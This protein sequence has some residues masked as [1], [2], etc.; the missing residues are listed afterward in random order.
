[1]TD[2]DAVDALALESDFA[3]VVRVDRAG[4]PEFAQAYGFAHR[5]HEIPNTVDTQFGTASGAK[6]FT[7]LA[8][9]HLIEQGTLELSTTARSVLGADLPLIDD[10]VTVEHLLAHRSG[11]GDYLD[12]EAEGEL[13]DYMLTVPLQEL[14][15]TEAFLPM[16]EGFPTKFAPGEQFSYCNG[17]FMVLAL[18]AERASGTPFHDLVRTSVIRRA[19]LVDT[20]YLRSDALPARAALGYL[21]VDGVTVTNIFH[22]PVLGNGDGGIYTTVSDISTFWLAFFAGR[23]VAPD[24]VAE[25]V[26]P[27]SDTEEESRRYGLGF[28]LHP[29]SPVVM[30]VGCD[31]GVSFLSAHDPETQLTATVISNSTYG[32]WPVADLLH[33]QLGFA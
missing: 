1:M 19:G 9:V 5:A 27:R 6:S 32:A 15:T 7:A 24:W 31:A 10:A 16:L 30:M 25:M 17:G 22:L 20:E 29:S 11:I 12:E 13:S 4:V 23:V 28:W 26:R 18:I 2:L 33:Q 21:E 8:V 3:G 14:A